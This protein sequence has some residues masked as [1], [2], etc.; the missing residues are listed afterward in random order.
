M[1]EQHRYSRVYKGPKPTL[2]KKNPYVVIGQPNT[3]KYLT[4]KQAA[5][6]EDLIPQFQ[7]S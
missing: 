7:Q 6:R 1:A 5:G 2:A 4:D 3:I